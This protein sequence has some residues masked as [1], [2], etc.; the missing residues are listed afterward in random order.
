MS[1]GK[2]SITTF[3]MTASC[4]I[5]GVLGI[6]I[7]LINQRGL[8]KIFHDKLALFFSQ[9]LKYAELIVNHTFDDVLSSVRLAQ[10]DDEEMEMLKEND[11]LSQEGLSKSLAQK[12]GQGLEFMMLFPLSSKRD[13]PPIV[14][15]SALYDVE[16]LE[17]ELRAH[18]SLHV[19]KKMLFFNDGK[20]RFLFMV[21][22][23][24]LLDVKSGEVVAVL[25]GG[26]ELGNN[27]ILKRT[28]EHNTHLSRVT[29]CY[30]EACFYTKDEAKETG[31]FEKGT[32]YVLDEKH[33]AHLYEDSI[34]LE[35]ERT[36]LS[37]RMVG[38]HLDFEEVNQAV[39]KE[40]LKTLFWIVI[41]LG[42][43]GVILRYWFINPLEG[44]KIFAKQL[45]ESGSS[46]HKPHFFIAEYH[47]LLVY[48]EKLFVSL[49]QT[50]L[51]LV[52][53]KEKIEKDMKIIDTYVI[54]STT[55]LKG[56]ITSVS[57]AFCDISG[58]V[59]QELIGQ[60]HNILRDPLMPSSVFKNL[61]ETITR[62]QVWHGEMS[63]IRK[64]GE[65]YWT[66][67]YIAPVYEEGEKVG[68]TAI[69][70]DITDKKRV[71]ELSIKDR[72][73]GLFN[74]LK[75]DEVFAYELG[76]AKRYQKPLSI[77]MLDIDYF[78]MTN[79][80]YGH[81]AGD[82]TLQL[83]AGILQKCSRKVDIVGRWGGEE[84]LIIVPNAHKDEVMVLAEKLRHSIETYA[85]PTVGH[86]TASLGVT[87]FRAN[88][89]HESMVERAD[90]AM[91][92]AKNTGRNKVVY[93]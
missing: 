62:G 60:N 58:Y 28:I 47:T 41:G 2:I 88:D 8:E 79:D 5:I 65:R 71:E 38:E 66:L 27:A 35:E 1:K 61:W 59:Q 11:T 86:K 32:V 81:Q 45:S 53:S 18:L 77:I 12:M 25:V 91:Y 40:F 52:K 75:L 6:W 51:E 72:L 56:H 93:V 26:M 3:F 83:F 64:N 9:N 17:E 29:F 49:A 22:S 67:S 31:V 19:N 50:R 46:K 63:N 84:F 90:E 44:L 85:F 76:Q 13:C 24:P 73:T 34:I 33:G 69:R 57:Q 37:L 54:I 4:L 10:F 70:Q 23:K 80:T 74:R 92:E 78:K 48:L 36:P 14:A 68:Y 87:S 89:T 39:G 42:L 21:A 7:F 43:F 55:D 20:E 15:S 30:E 16:H 82:T